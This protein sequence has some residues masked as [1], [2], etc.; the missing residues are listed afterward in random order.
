M[1]KTL[2]G[3]LTFRYD[4]LLG[5]V[6]QFRL[7]SVSSDAPN[8]WCETNTIY[9]EFKSMHYQKYECQKNEV[10]ARSLKVALTNLFT[11]LSNSHAHGE[12]KF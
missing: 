3:G 1:N 10:K 5:S 6:C 4:S 9:I 11:T 12:E 7:S 8:I 2:S